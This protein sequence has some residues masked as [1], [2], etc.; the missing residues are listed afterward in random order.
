LE[1]PKQ[2]QKI[3][4]CKYK[5]Y[6]YQDF[7]AIGATIDF[8]LVISKKS[9]EMEKGS[10]LEWLYR[11]LSEPKRLWNALLRFMVPPFG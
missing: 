10:S 3:Y 4:L 6:K 8:K 7:L 5:D 1:A 11:L 2:E 9:T